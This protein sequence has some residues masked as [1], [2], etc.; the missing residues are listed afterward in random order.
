MTD[1]FKDRLK[2]TAERLR[3]ERERVAT[4]KAEA[5]AREQARVLKL[6]THT[7]EWANSILPRLHSAVETANDIVAEVQL[8]AS[9]TVGEAFNASGMA[10]VRLPAVEVTRVIPPPK[11]QPSLPTR[12]VRSGRTLMPPPPANTVKKMASLR[13]FLEQDDT[14]CVLKDNYKYRPIAEFKPVLFEKFK[15]EDIEELVAEFV[16]SGLLGY[17]PHAPQLPVEDQSSESLPDEPAAGGEHTAQSGQ[18]VSAIRANHSTIVVASKSLIAL[19]DEKI[20]TLNSQIPNEELAKEKWDR[21]IETYRDMRDAT[22]ALATAIEAFIG[23]AS[24]ESQAVGATFSFSRG[25]KNWWTEKHI[26]ICERSFDSGLFALGVMLCY[27]AGAGGPIS[28]VIAAT[29]VKGQPIIDA[30][31]AWSASKDKSK[32]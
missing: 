5:M 17:D 16:N 15:H 29:V 3:S 13:I 21:E 24:K 32:G 7:Q 4:A 10:T 9:S 20:G 28:A 12:P 14:I 8:K 26:T 11:S 31:K 30:L 27:Y 6:Q 23:D 1:S 18:V 22:Q 2:L 25:L 19:L